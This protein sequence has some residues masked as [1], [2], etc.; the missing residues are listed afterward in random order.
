MIKFKNIRP[1]I[2]LTFFSLMVFNSEGL[3]GLKF[4][5]R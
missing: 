3:R 2:V 1:G 5:A 4:N